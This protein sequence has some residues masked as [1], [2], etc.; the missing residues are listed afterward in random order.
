MRGCRL[1]AFARAGQARTMADVKKKCRFS[2]SARL[3]FQERKGLP[4]ASKMLFFSPF[5]Y[6]LDAGNSCPASLFFPKRLLFVVVGGFSAEPVPWLSGCRGS[7]DGF[8]RHCDRMATA[9]G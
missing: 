5:L 4:G 8:L 1:P 3:L 9:V 7:V 6:A 2:Q